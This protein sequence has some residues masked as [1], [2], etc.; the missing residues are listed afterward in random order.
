[1][2]VLG[3]PSTVPV[4]TDEM[5]MLASAVRRGLK[6]PAAGRR[7]AVRLLRGV[8][9][10]GRRDRP[11]V[12]Q[13]GRLRRGQARARRQQRAARP[14]DRRGRHPR[15]GPRRPDA[16][17]GDRAGRLPRPGPHRRARAVGGARRAGAARR[18]GCFSIVFEAIPAAVSELV[19]EQ[20][21][22][23]G[24][25]DRRR[26]GHRRPGARV[27]RPARDLRRPRAALRQALRRAQ[28]ADGRRRRRVRRRGPRWRVPGARALL[29]DRRA[30]ADRVPEALGAA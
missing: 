29:L 14:R 15:D 16:P 2:T 19:M 8:R 28:G 11:A 27:P 23:P 20:H 24:D 10:A 3:Y 22:D 9:R 13:G 5:L 17:D 21:R 25:R 4:S 26:P 6:H 18:P 30:G 1:M 7:P 12:R